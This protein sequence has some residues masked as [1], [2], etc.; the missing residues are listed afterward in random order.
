MPNLVLDIGNTRT[1]AAIFHHREMVRKAAWESVSPAQL[2][3][4]TY[5]QNIGNVI[6]SAVAN[7][8][9]E[10][11]QW[12]KDRFPCLTLSHDTPLPFCL[13]YST[14]Q[15]L[16][17]DRIAAIAGAFDR[18]PGRN[19]LVIDAGTCIKYDVLTAAGEFP[20][21]N[22]APGLDMRLK[23]MHHFTARLPLTD[24]KDWQGKSYWLGESTRDAL[25]NGGLLGA[26]LEAE[27]FIRL[28]RQR[29]HPL[30][31]ILTGGDADFFAKNLKTKIFADPDLVLV[32][33]NKILQHNANV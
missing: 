15:T 24:K 21:G 22:I 6:L 27:G 13:T 30:K 25:L 10:V 9:P 2:L 11:A 29:F 1:K 23:A 20:G 7:V 12:L 32:G 17:K 4:F 16:G 31:V 26:L 3:D 14:P 33:L 18:F 19:C 5:N 28:C 8:E